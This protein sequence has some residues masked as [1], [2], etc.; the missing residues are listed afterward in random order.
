ME[1]SVLT[2]VVLP[3]SLAIIM[4]GMGL[5]LVLDD[6]KRVVQYPKAALIGLTNQLIL[7]P[8]IA[9]LLARTFDLSPLLAAGLMLIAACPGGV[10]SNLITHVSKGDIALSVTL[11]AIASFITIFT[12]PLI[13]AFS[14]TYFTGETSDPIELPFGKTILQIMVIT[15][16]PI[17]IGMAIR[18]FKP[19]FADSM[20]RPMRLAST[21]IFILVLAGIIAANKDL[22]VSSFKRV[23]LVTLLLN[24]LTMGLGYATARLFRLN[25]RQSIAITIESGIQNGTLA[26]VIATTILMQNEM[27]IPPAVYSLIMFITGGFLMWY[28]GRRKDE[29]MVPG[30]A[31]S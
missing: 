3:L 12:I 8:L 14:L 20:E 1:S 23:G 7:L 5:S 18:H 9:F 2:S 27:T 22:I 25:L 29:K 24:L 31:V 19:A 4:I 11:T 10:T 6:F 28:F 17:S 21:I 16:I 26:L 30:E 15:V 13:L